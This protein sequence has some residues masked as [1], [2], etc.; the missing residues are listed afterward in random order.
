MSALM[1]R[2]PRLGASGGILV[3][4]GAAPPDHFHNGLPYEANGAL[5]FDTNNGISHYH[6]GLPFTAASRLVTKGGVLGFFGSGAA[7]FISPDTLLAK[8]LTAPTVFSSGVGYTTAGE[9]ATSL[10]P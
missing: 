9:I 3:V 1:Q 2:V 6:Q 5:C 4:D 7:P 8:D 10:V